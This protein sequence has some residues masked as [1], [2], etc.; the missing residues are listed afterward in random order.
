[1]AIEQLVDDDLKATGAAM[2]GCLRRIRGTHN[3]LVEL[4]NL[5]GEP[6]DEVLDL[7]QYTF[8]DVAVDFTPVSWVSG[9]IQLG[10]DFLQD[11][12]ERLA[13]QD[14]VRGDHAVGHDA[15][16]HQI[17]HRVYSIA[18]PPLRLVTVP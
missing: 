16:H 8:T 17:H 3:P 2:N 14:D 18:L 10:L 5:T 12:L 15:L 11:G 1:M 13:K 7:V 6:L 4:A 9:R